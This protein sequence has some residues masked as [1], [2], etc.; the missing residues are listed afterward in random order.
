MIAFEED[1]G[2]IDTKAGPVGRA[3]RQQRS[4]SA[5]ESYA[6][7]HDAGSLSASKTMYSALLPASPPKAGQ[8]Y[9]FEVDMDRCTGCKSC[10]AACHSLNGLE[11]L[12]TW[13]STGLLLGGTAEQ[14][15]QQTVTTACH[16]C[17]DPACM[18]GC[19][20]KAYE[21]DPVTGIVKHLDDQCIGCKYCTL[22]CPYDV[23]QYSK[24][25]GIVRKCDM[26]SDRLAVG[27]APACVQAC[28]TAAIRIRTVDVDDVTER[29][30]AES[31][32]PAAPSPG[33]T[34]PTTR[35]KSKRVQPANLLPADYHRVQQEAGHIPLVVMLVLTQLSV[36]HFC[37]IS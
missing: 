4:L 32:L 36:A 23:P 34:R 20:V 11:P 19:P 25:L 8:Q 29:C 12:E 14:P 28:P 37:G 10:V 22:T 7:K 6:Q 35:Y 30:E 27:E 24:R 3:L 13:R 15:Y 9:A 2:L 1:L 18:N 26:C 17:L 16:H 33:L 31:F 21:K 5:V